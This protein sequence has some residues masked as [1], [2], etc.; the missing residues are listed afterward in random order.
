MSEYKDT[1]RIDY[2]QRGDLDDIAVGSVDLFRM[3]RMSDGGFW[4][5][6][7]RSNGKKDIVFWLNATKNEN[8]TPRDPN[9][10]RI[11]GSHA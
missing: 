6:L 4:I 3:E 10:C 7:Y 5:K 11:N 2:N 1:E 9:E 8:P